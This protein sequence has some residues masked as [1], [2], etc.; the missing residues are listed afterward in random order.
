MA[1]RILFSL[2]LALSVALLGTTATYAAL[3]VP[4]QQQNGLD[5]GDGPGDWDP[6]NAPTMTET[7]AS[8]GIYS[9]AVSSIDPN[10]L[11]KFKILDDEGS[12]PFDWNTSTQLTP[13]NSWFLTGSTGAATISID[14]NTYDDGY[15]PTTNRVTSSTD[16]TELPGVFGVGDWMEEAG[17]AG[18]WDPGDL[19]FQMTED[20]N[21]SGLFSL[22]V[23][24]STPGAYQWKA[25]K[26]DWDGQWGTDGRND[27]ATTWSFNTV[28]ADQDVTFLVDTSLG[29]VSFQT[30][31]FV[32]GDTNNDTFVTLEDFDPIRDNFLKN[33]FVRAEGDLDGDGVVGVSD[34]HEWKTAYLMT[35][36]VAASATVPEP[37]GVALLVFACLGTFVRRRRGIA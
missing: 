17:G 25:T 19:M 6:P 34:F 26:G 33:T 14:T 21:A 10:A 8:S 9:L 5:D 7:P 13:T 32:P 30:A 2:T 27:N 28:E 20:P 16:A 11:Y 24:I 31:T 1:K 15:L 4:G 22:D 18:D 37:S 36:N 35:L 3:G 12:P 29:A 23:T